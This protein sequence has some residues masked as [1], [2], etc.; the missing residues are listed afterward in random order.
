MIR[1]RPEL[2]PEVRAL[3]A[4][5]RVLQPRPAAVR[6]RALA[7]ARA[8]LAVAGTP[9]LRPAAPRPAKVK[10]GWAAALTLIGV[11]TAAAAAVGYQIGTRQRSMPAGA[12]PSAAASIAVTAPAAV[13][14]P[15]PV[16]LPSV[17][18]P[19]ATARAGDERL[20][21]PADALHA[22]MRLLRRARAAVSRGDFAAALP[23][24][25][26]HARLFRA[27]RL[28]EEREALRVSALAGLG[29]AD[30]ARRAAAAFKARFPHSVLLPA[31]QRVQPSRP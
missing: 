15:S 25:A 30:E 22:E 31:V 5:E 17:A 12:P 9:T 28:T 26:R 20:T 7:R 18:P 3:L 13:R 23:A 10:L 27:G 4:R 21:A 6:A 2:S 19:P 16:A 8:A 14:P 1:S 29:R 24:I 11:A